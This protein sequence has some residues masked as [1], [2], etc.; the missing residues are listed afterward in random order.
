MFSASIIFVL[1]VVNTLYAL[2]L[3]SMARAREHRPPGRDRTEFE[4]QSREREAA[5]GECRA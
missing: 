2:R 5:R 1:L 3:S 4:I